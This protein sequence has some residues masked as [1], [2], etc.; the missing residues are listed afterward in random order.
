M[1]VPGVNSQLKPV[2]RDLPRFQV[3]SDYEKEM[4]K[5]YEIGL[6]DTIG[7]IDTKLKEILNIKN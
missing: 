6:K 3:I 2:Y 4:K 7:R 5:N 1:A